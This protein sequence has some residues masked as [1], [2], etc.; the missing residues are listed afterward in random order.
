MAKV[1]Y[2]LAPDSEKDEEGKDEM[3]CETGAQ[4]ASEVE[5]K[6]APAQEEKDSEEAEEK[7]RPATLLWVM[8]KLSL[9]AKREAAYSPKSPLKVSKNCIVPSLLWL[10]ILH[11]EE[12]C[13]LLPLTPREI[14]RGGCQE[15]EKFAVAER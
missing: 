7:S 4:D 11:G 3:D 12:G 15:A 9:M 6:E 1:L 10:K 8:K 5:G 14:I 2:L 13:A